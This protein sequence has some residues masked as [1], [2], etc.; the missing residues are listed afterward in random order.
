MG[1]AS[2]VTMALIGRRHDA[3][4][5]EKAVIRLP[6]RC[7]H[8]EEQFGRV[9]ARLLLRIISGCGSVCGW[10]DHDSGAG[11]AVRA[12]DAHRTVGTMTRYCLWWYHRETPTSA[13]PFS[14]ITLSKVSH[15]AQCDGWKWRG[16][17]WHHVTSK[18]LSDLT[19]LSAKEGTHFPCGGYL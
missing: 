18:H 11:S 15:F 13:K 14:T 17:C 12:P 2:L 4:A 6:T 3:I 7:R 16:A 10:A 9:T 5:I 1:M 19:Y 8:V